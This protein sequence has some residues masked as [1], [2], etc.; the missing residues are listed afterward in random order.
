[1]D[2]LEP[3]LDPLR[4]TNDDK[5]K[6]TNLT[7]KAESWTSGLNGSIV[8]IGERDLNSPDDMIRIEAKDLLKADEANESS[9][10]SS[11]YIT[12]GAEIKREPLESV[13]LGSTIEDL[14]PDDN[15]NPKIQFQSKIFNSYKRYRIRN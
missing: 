14:D 8:K 7:F 10:T 15:G 4:P 5:K 11:K 1:M 12:T 13:M 9:P 3:D 2:P 6:S